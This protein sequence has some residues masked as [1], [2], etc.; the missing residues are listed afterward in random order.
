[1][2]FKRFLSFFFLLFTAVSL[3]GREIPNYVAPTEYETVDPLELV[4]SERFDLMA[5]YLLAK[6][7]TVGLDTPWFHALYEKH[8]QVWNG[9]HEDYPAVAI[10][11]FNCAREYQEKKDIE[12]YISCFKKLINSIQNDGFDLSESVIPT[13]RYLQIKDGAHR[14]AACLLIDK[15]IYCKRFNDNNFINVSSAFFK[16]A[17]LDEDFLDS[18]ALEY[19]RLKSNTY[20]VNLFP[21]SLKNIKMVRNILAKHGTI[22]YEKDAKIF[23]NG[24]FNLI[25]TFYDD[26]DGPVENQKAYFEGPLYKMH[27]CFPGKYKEHAIKFVLFECDS[28]EKTKECK[29]EVRAFFKSYDVIHINDTHEETIRLA[30]T[31]FNNNSLHFL[32]H[33]SRK[34]FKKFEAYFWKYKQWLTECKYPVEEFCIDTSAVLSAYGA[35]DCADLDYLHFGEPIESGITGIDDHSCELKYHTTSKDDIIFNPKNHFY[36]KGIKFCSLDRIISMKQKR[37]EAKDRKDI[38][39]SELLAPKGASF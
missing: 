5:K 12:E 10:P 31:A 6:S 15:P 25:K 19:C 13:N 34:F 30:E 32:N 2:N 17:G 20:I 35:R 11:N 21:G 18:M 29:Q 39:M 24:P 26:G 9:C 1:M 27:A 14:V 4:V 16:K 7:I 37:N 8:L 22:V 23:K 3:I 36:Y 38:A 33:S 28:H